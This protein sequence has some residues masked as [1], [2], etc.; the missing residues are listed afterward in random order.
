M[1][2]SV[3]ILCQSRTFIGVLAVFIAANA[4]S[5]VRHRFWPICCDQEVTIGFPVPFHISGGIAG[6]SNFY[7]LGLLLDIVVALT[8]AVTLTWVVRL[9]RSWQAD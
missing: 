4:W 2:F 5:W 8:I 9:I 3:R 6:L 1:K 7:L